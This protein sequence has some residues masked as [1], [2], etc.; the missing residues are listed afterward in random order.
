[1]IL[2]RCNFDLLFY[3][4]TIF[5]LKL[6]ILNSLTLCTESVVCIKIFFFLTLIFMRPN[7]GERPYITI[8]EHGM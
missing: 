6:K 3:N 1:M 7:I 2:N 8:N 4:N 5:L